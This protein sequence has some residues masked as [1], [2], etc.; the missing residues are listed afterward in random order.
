MPSDLPTEPPSR[1]NLPVE[2]QELLQFV[3]DN[4]PVLVGYANTS[5][6]VVFLNRPFIDLLGGKS[7]D[8]IGRPISKIIEPEAYSIA[9]PFIQRALQGETVNYETSLTD[10]KG[11]RRSFNA[12]LVP[13]R[14]SDGNIKGYVVMMSDITEQ[15]RMEEALIAGEERYRMLVE[16][17]GEGIAFFDENMVFEYINTAGEGIIGAA[18]GTLIGRTFSDFVPPSQMPILRHQIETRTRGESSS[19]ELKIVALD[20][21]TRQLLITAT[22]RFDREGVYR[23]SFVIFRD[24]TD[25][26]LLEDKLRYQVTHDVLTGLYNRYFFQEEVARLEYS[27][28]F[29]ISFIMI[30]LDNL[31]E[32]NDTF[33]HSTGDDL[34]KLFSSRLRAMFRT[35]D[36]VARFGGDEFVVLLPNTPNKALRK[37]LARLRKQLDQ[38]TWIH[39]NRP[40]RFE[41]SIG[42]STAPVGQPLKTAFDRA[43]QN[44]YRNKRKRQRDART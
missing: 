20:G 15:K 16:N 6:H 39:Q 35:E 9:E 29:P 8:L 1:T 12:T 38:E 13:H 28:Q 19:Y 5:M 42:G 33:G 22:P 36:V 2:P 17:Q 44:M 31:K 30:D 4:L 10:P 24:I 37:I 26:K 11:I 3:I 27:R 34:L 32:I 41:Y 23:G 18:P 40:I 7:E 14:G 43:D 25:R 21:S